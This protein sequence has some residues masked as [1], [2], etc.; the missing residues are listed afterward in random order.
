[1]R[2]HL[3][4]HDPDPINR[5]NINL[6]ADNKGHHIS[7]TDVFRMEA[8]PPLANFDWLLVMGGSQHAW[9]EEIH[10]WLAGE[11]EFI[12]QALANGKPI[13]GIC[14]GAQLLAESLGGRVF[15]NREKEIGW[16]KVSLNHEGQR[17]FLFRNVPASFISFH[18][19]SDHFSLPPECTCLAYSEVTQNQ[20]FVHHRLPV[21]GV[22][23]HP[24]YTRE[25]VESYSEAYGHEWVQGPYVAGKEA[26]LAETRQLP[27][28]YWLMEKLLDNFSLK[29]G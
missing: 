1:M 13:L 8:L 23:F 12:S 25:M 21:A 11:K 5:T 17:S 27:D 16:Y 26:V 18:W 29:F 14:F 15:S 28:T 7:K 4:E 24:E 9:E 20:A 3:L 22:Q 10:P 6:W 19:H 2:L